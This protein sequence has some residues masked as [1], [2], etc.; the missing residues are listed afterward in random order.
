MSI[1]SGLRKFREWLANGKN[2]TTCG[3]TALKS[4]LKNVDI[5]EGFPNYTVSDSFQPDFSGY[6]EVF[7]FLKR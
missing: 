6:S 7:L 4:K 2:S 5:I 1:L 3:R